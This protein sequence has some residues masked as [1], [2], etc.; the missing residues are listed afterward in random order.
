MNILWYLAV[1]V[2]C[3]PLLGAITVGLLN[4]KLSRSLAHWITCSLMLVCFGA[5]SSILVG[6]LIGKFNTVDIDLYVWGNTSNLSIAVGFLLDRLSALMIAIVSFVSLVVHVYSIGYMHDDP[7]YQRFF[8]Y[9]SLFTFGML[10]L[11]MANNFAQLFFGWEAVGLM[12][13]LLIGFWYKKEA[14]NFASLKAFLINRIGDMGFVLGIAAVLYY[15]NSL[16]FKT[17]FAQISTLVAT[18][19]MLAITNTVQWPAISFIC[20]CLFIGAMA[21]SA[22]IPLHVWLPDSMEGPTPISALIHAA[23]M[24]TAG[25]F[26][27][28][29]MSPLY[30]Y[31]ETALTLMLIIGSLTCL[32]MAILAIV[33]TDIKRIIA[34]STLS[35]LGYM[36]VALGASAYAA[37]IFHLVTHACFK[38]LLFLGAGAAIL[39][40]HHDQNI[41]K[42][43]NL[44]KYMPITAVTMLIGNLALLG[45]PG[46]SGFYSKDL[47][48]ASVR[49]SSLTFSTIAYYIILFTVLITTFYAARLMLV[50]FRTQERMAEDVREHLH[51]PRKVIWVPLIILAI[52]SLFLGMIMITSILNQFFG[53]AIF[54]LPAHDT[55]AMFKTQDFHGWFSM[56]LHGFV[57]LPF[58]CILMGMCLAWLCYEK[59]PALP[60]IIQNDAKL[61]TRILLA[62][63]GFDDFNEKIIMPAT[64]KLGN[65]CWQIGDVLCIDGIMVNGTANSVGRVAGVLKHAQT[66]YLYHYIFIIVAGLLALLVWTMFL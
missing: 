30:E 34:Y 49:N 53:D 26:M 63:F 64:R 35:Q 29:R 58:V 12:S 61:M 57:S 7:G 28:A 47:I 55:V 65:Y 5:S 50:A 15:F 14:A 46:T 40:V 23:T 9:I 1:T 31:S 39:A 32:F 11:V 36:V 48:I 20:I 6:F 2:V 4:K 25:I 18:N 19:P 17:V 33:Q 51:E 44:H 27:V 3:A 60:G 38:A 52:P 10:M 66:G 24:V 37:G 54:V 13:Y 43:G 8:C 56:W 59:Y 22:Q 41:F 16:H 45:F 62:K 42:M 21:K